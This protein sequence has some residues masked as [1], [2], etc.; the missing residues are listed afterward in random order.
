MDS[1][2]FEIRQLTGN[3]KLNAAICNAQFHIHEV[4]R[5]IPGHEPLPRGPEHDGCYSV[6]LSVADLETLI[7][8]AQQAPSPACETAGEEE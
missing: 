5:G 6:T 8:Y 2:Q 4:T 7:R 1:N 3:K